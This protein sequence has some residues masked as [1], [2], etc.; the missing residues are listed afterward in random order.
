MRDRRE[1]GRIR[2]FKGKGAPMTEFIMYLWKVITIFGLGV[3]LG[4][5]Q[6]DKNRDRTAQQIADH[7]LKFYEAKPKELAK[8]HEL[9]KKI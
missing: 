1:G 6:R 2:D 3:F 5:Y 4:W 7:L 9:K 8:I